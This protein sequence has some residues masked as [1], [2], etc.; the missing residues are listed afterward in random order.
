MC[1]VCDDRLLYI[2]D[3]RSLILQV[4]KKAADFQEH[5][6]RLAAQELCEEYARN[7]FPKEDLPKWLLFVG[8]AWLMCLLSCRLQAP[9]KESTRVDC[10]IK[11]F[12]RVLLLLGSW[13]SRPPD[14]TVLYIPLA[15]DMDSRVCLDRPWESCLGQA[16][17]PGVRF[18]SPAVEWTCLAQ[19]D[20]PGHQTAGKPS[21]FSYAPTQLGN[22]TLLIISHVHA[23]VLN[24]PN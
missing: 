23:F 22:S 21:I 24:R 3:V 16:A 7:F 9:K 2:V 10:N 18:C 15:M 17:S 6:C 8:Y 4:L 13:P 1:D 11:Q 19:A 20:S 5:C 14:L 12:P